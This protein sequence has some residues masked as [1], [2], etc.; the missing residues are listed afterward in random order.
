MP[1]EPE[2][3]GFNSIRRFIRFFTR[4]EVKTPLSFLFKIVPYLIA[5][6]FIILYAPI[7]DELK[8]RLVKLTFSG[9][10]GLC[11]IVLLFGWFRPKNLVYGETGHRAEHRMDLGTEKKTIGHGELEELEPTQNKEPVL[12]K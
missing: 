8:E 9:L 10:L 5:A 6:L 7:T 3:W 2:G 12:L 1:P 11:G 4:E